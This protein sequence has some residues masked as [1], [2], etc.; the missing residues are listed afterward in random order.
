MNKER[1]PV[2]L[3]EPAALAGSNGLAQALLDQ[4]KKK[5]EYGQMN[6][7]NQLYVIKRTACIEAS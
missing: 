6:Q 3:L 2:L 4:Q 5:K 1:S 7:H